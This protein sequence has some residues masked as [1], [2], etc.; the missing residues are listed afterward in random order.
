[1]AV[2]VVGLLFSKKMQNALRLRSGHT[3]SSIFK[4]RSS[5]RSQWTP[6]SLNDFSLDPK[7][8]VL[9]TPSPDMF[10]LRLY[11][12]AAPSEEVT[13]CHM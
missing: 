1:V 8:K 9:T 12:R 11:A 5:T 13:C 10:V 3:G 7:T 6:I 2:T 4:G